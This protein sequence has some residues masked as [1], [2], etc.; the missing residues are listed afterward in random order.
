MYTDLDQFKEYGTVHLI[1]PET[2]ARCWID[3]DTFEIEPFNN[4]NFEDDAS[5]RLVLRFDF[6][7]TVKD[8]LHLISEKTSQDED[9]LMIRRILVGRNWCTKAGITQLSHPIFRRDYDHEVF[10]VR[11][12]KEDEV[13]KINMD[14]EFSWDDTPSNILQPILR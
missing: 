8:L 12:K 13:G 7:A 5:Q 1:S 3:P 14:C 9:N 4:D 10:Y 2:C 6:K 11:M